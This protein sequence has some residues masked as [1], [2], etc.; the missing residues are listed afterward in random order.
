MIFLTSLAAFSVK[1][2]LIA[3]SPVSRTI[4]QA[5]RQVSDLDNL[6]YRQVK[7]GVIPN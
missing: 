4:P 3:F 2:T 5:D 1:V 6:S 7:S